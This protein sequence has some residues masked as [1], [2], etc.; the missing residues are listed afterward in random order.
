MRT[1]TSRRV[2]RVNFIRPNSVLRG[3]YFYKAP[4]RD[5]KNQQHLSAERKEIRLQEVTRSNKPANLTS[6][7]PKYRTTLPAKT[8]PRISTQS[9]WPS[10]MKPHKLRSLWTVPFSMTGDL[11]LTPH[12]TVTVLEEKSFRSSGVMLDKFPR[13]SWRP[14]VLDQKLGLMEW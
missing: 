3:S 7:L 11:L 8:F 13:E 14:T 6:R 2:L 1:K 4:R 5:H 12:R 9:S 10:K